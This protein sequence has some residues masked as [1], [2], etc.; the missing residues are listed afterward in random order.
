MHK[1]A[2][3]LPVYKK[4]SLEILST[5]YLYEIVRLYVVLLG[6]VSDRDPRF[7]SRFW[8]KL[9]ETLGTK[10]RFSMTYHPQTDVQSERTIQTLEDILRACIM[11]FGGSWGQYLTL[12][13][14]VYNN[15]Y[16]SS[17]QMA[18]Y[19]VLYGRKCRSPIYWDK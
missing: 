14:F 1:S 13:E 16:H 2:H 18:L 6:I 8:Q 5:L 3:F 4:Y 9:Q 7:V 15:S 19:E 12:V 10:L 17:I 11:D